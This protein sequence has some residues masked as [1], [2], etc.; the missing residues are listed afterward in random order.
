MKQD[1]C[2]VGS[3]SRSREKAGDEGR[4]A[5]TLTPTLSRKREREPMSLRYRGN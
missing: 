4:C 1:D 5:P 2:R 3:F